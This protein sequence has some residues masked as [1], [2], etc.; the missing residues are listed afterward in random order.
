MNLVIGP[1]GSGKSTIVCA[2]CLGLGYPPGVLGRATSVGDY[3]QHGKDIAEIGI[4]LA[5]KE[6]GKTF[7][8]KR[9]IKRENNSN[10][11]SL[12]GTYYRVGFL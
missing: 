12:N 6:E 11:Y 4:E 7:T 9:R 10:T 5:D 2:I 1:N 3:I 8:I